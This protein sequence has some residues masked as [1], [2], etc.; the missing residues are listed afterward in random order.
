MLHAGQVF[1]GRPFYH[2]FNESGSFL[3]SS[4]AIG[5]LVEESAALTY[6]RFLTGP[7]TLTGSRDLI[8]VKFTR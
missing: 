7:S 4:L 6:T 5:L 8:G 2:S 1:G 3:T